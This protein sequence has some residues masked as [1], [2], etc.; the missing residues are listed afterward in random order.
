MLQACC[1]LSGRSLQGPLSGS[2]QLEILDTQHMGITKE[3]MRDLRV[4]CPPLRN[5]LYT[6]PTDP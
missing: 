1:G 6:N 5:L 3:E 4:L 2:R